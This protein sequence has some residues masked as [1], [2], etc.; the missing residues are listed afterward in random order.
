MWTISLQSFNRSAVVPTKLGFLN[1][2]LAILFIRS[3]PGR[4]IPYHKVTQVF[5]YMR[6]QITEK[7]FDH[8]TPQFVE[9]YQGGR[10]YTDGIKLLPHVKQLI[11]TL[12][13]GPDI[14]VPLLFVLNG[15]VAVTTLPEQWLLF[16]MAHPYINIYLAIS[17]PQDRVQR[18]PI[19]M[20]SNPYSQPPHP[21]W[22]L[23]SLHQILSC[24]NGTDSD[25]TCSFIL[26][27]WKRS[28]YGRNHIS[29]GY[30]L[31]EQNRNAI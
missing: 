11:S 22:I 24:W 7:L 5:N 17:M 2:N 9:S 23:R 16:T 27:G 1:I 3:S 13:A 31:I 6:E 10:S 28:T 8:W 29:M 18:A 25:P 19:G 12:P 30:D 20:W 15:K 4:I 26:G 14:P 21:V